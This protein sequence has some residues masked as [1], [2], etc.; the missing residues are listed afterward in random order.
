[1]VWSG[2]GRQTILRYGIEPDNSP[3]SFPFRTVCT[4]TKA[5]VVLT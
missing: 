4:I 2:D 3:S 5:V 1:M